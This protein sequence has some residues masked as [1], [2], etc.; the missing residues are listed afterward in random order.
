MYVNT[1]RSL[2]ESYKAIYEA[3]G[4][5]GILWEDY[6]CDGFA[7]E[8]QQKEM[9]FYS[10]KIAEAMQT[11]A[12]KKWSEEDREDW[13]LDEKSA[14]FSY[15]PAYVRSEIERVRNLRNPEQGPKT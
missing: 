1:V 3:G 12:A 11:E 5:P 8:T 4:I 7:T 9:K 2:F 13:V 6:L 15:P 14:V 10:K